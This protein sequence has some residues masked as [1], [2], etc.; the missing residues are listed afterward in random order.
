MVYYAYAHCIMNY[1]IIF[2]GTSSCSLRVLGEFAKLCKATII[3]VISVCLSVSLSVR[4][5]ICPSAWNSSP[6]PGQILIE[7]DVL[8]IFLKAVE[9]IQVLL[10][11]DNNNGHITRRPKY[12]YDKL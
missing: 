6:P 2:W 3:L 1:G 12:I 4:L 8:S 9:I 10:I 5:C 7:F 11:S